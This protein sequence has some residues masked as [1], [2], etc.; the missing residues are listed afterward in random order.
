[1]IKKSFLKSLASF[2]VTT[3]ISLVFI[4]SVPILAKVIFLFGLIGS[5]IYF[6]Y[7]VIS[8]DNDFY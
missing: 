3:S 8:G 5:I 6:V 1:M 2:G 7:S 4:K